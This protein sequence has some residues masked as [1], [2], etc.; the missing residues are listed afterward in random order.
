MNRNVE[1]HFS[2]VPYI[3][4]PRSIFDRSYGHK[5]SF[6]SSLL[7]PFY[8][9]QNVLPGDTFRVTTSKVVRLQTLLT[10]IMDNMYLDTYYFFVPWRLVWDHVRE[11]FGENTQSAWIQNIEYKIPGIASPEGGF[12]TGTIAD[13]M[14]L[15]V[16][17]E[18]SAEDDACP[19][20]LPFRAYALICNEFFRDQNLS[21]PL[22]I[23]TGDA[24]QQGTNG[25]S[26]INDVPNGGKPFKVAK[27]HDLFSSCLPSPQKGD[28]VRV[29]FSGNAPVYSYVEKVPFDNWLDGD[30]T[31]MVV[32]PRNSSLSAYPEFDS[33]LIA[34]TGNN[35]MTFTTNS[36]ETRAFTEYLG[37]MTGGMAPL[38]LWADLSDTLAP[39]VNELRLAFQL[40]RYY[41]HLASGG[42][43][44]IEW[45]KEFFGAVSSDARLQRPEYL[46]GNRVPIN[47]SEV[48]NTSQSKD[49]FLGD[50]GAMSATA[51]IH[52]DFVKSFTEHGIILGLMCVRY[53]HSYS[54][55]IS[56]DWTRRTLM[57]QYNPTFAHLGEMPVYTYEIY[58]DGNMN[59]KD[60][61]G[62]NEAWSSYRYKPDQVTGEMRPGITNSLASWHLGDYYTEAPTLSDDWI[63]ED[64]TNVDRVISVTSQVANQF[65]CDI[66]V[67][68]IATRVMPMYS[69]PGLIDHF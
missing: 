43:R 7:I 57:D 44:Y 47:I 26:Y 60:V 51:D 61:F 23:P 39:T 6:D 18:W 52:D 41:E 55:G 69:V 3:D 46:G 21:D 58:A 15:P 49:D 35:N 59:N 65:W 25:D 8:L 29:G 1:S 31:Y 37:S 22:N 66:Y 20:A 9:E 36:Q 13:Y 17:V 50:T 11:F 14:G 54:Q 16:G 19:S 67:R 10:P 30:K 48:L 12:A 24:D 32:Q 28:P 45:C 62:Y 42:S 27:F 53:D 38:N 34:P 33:K 68:N 4:K 40:Q 63:R 5:T 64:M 2:E 56:R